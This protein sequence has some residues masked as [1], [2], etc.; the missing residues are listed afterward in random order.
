V[1]TSPRYKPCPP[2]LLDHGSCC[3]T[4]ARYFHLARAASSRRCCCSRRH[5]I[6]VLSLRRMVFA[7]SATAIRRTTCRSVMFCVTRC[8]LMHTPN[9]VLGLQV[10][11][12]TALGGVK[13][14]RCQEAGKLCCCFPSIS[15]YVLTEESALKFQAKSTFQDS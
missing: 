11:L 10:G 5:S 12:K 1:W 14:F 3:C 13:W 2:Y 15:E 4:A 7:T 8:Y 9:Y 6:S